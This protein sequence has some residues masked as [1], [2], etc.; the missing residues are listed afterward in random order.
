MMMSIEDILKKDKQILESAEAVKVTQE[1]FTKGFF[2][3]MKYAMILG[4]VMEKRKKFA[5]DPSFTVG[6]G[7]LNADAEERLKADFMRRMS[8]SSLTEKG[9][10]PD[11]MENASLVIGAFVEAFSVVGDLS[12]VSESSSREELQALYSAAKENKAERVSDF[13]EKF[14]KKTYGSD[15]TEVQGIQSVLKDEQSMPSRPSDKMSP[16]P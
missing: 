10:N 13:I 16:S 11:K 15:I 12:V 2:S 5:S 7:K 9:N 8:K 14:H 6:G 3:K 1:K 4:P